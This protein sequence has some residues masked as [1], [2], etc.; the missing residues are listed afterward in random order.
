[1]YF[2]SHLFI[3][4]NGNVAVDP[5]SLDEADA[6]ELRDLGG[7]ASIVVTNRDHARDAVSLKERFDAKIVASAREANEFPFTVDVLM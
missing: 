7:V 2:N 6:A 3:R 5:L 1:M 4:P